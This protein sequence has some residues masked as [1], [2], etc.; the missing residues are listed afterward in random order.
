[1]MWV[2]FIS[3]LRAGNG[4]TDGLFVNYAVEMMG[5]CEGK[6]KMKVQKYKKIS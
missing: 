6:M 4:L 1:M 5:C 2:V 3:I